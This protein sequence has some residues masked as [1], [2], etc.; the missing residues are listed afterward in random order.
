MRDSLTNL[1][2]MWD[3]AIENTDIFNQQDLFEIL[4]AHLGH[5]VTSALRATN[6]NIRPCY[7]FIPCNECDYF[8]FCS[9]QY[10]AMKIR[11]KEECQQN[12]EKYVSSFHSQPT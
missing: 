8:K 11:S 10:E 7:A 5:T 6:K 9:V 1:N 4:V 2:T 3:I 12:L